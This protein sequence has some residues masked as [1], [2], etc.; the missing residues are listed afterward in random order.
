MW[1]VIDDSPVL[2]VSVGF[3]FSFANQLHFHQTPDAK[4]DLKY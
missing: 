4:E 2:E 1:R 3:H